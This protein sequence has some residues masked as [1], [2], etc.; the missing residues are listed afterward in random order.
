ML[1]GKGR[2]SFSPTTGNFRLDAV[3]PIS[4]SR[5]FIDFCN[6]RISAATPLQLRRNVFLILA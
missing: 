1:E 5:D 4:L 3:F 6:S 2:E